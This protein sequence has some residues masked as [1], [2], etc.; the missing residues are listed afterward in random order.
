MDGK[1]EVSGQ[2]QTEGQ[3]DDIPVDKEAEDVVSDVMEGQ[4][5]DQDVSEPVNKLQVL[6]LNFFIKNKIRYCCSYHLLLPCH[7]C[8]GVIFSIFHG[9]LVT[10]QD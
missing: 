7:A 9:K 2:P 8:F 1:G 4:M 6:L 5:G 10:I 3:G